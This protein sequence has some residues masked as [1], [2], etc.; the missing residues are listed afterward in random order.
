MRRGAEEDERAEE[1]AAVVDDEKE[2]ESNS[3][4]SVVAD[5]TSGKNVAIVNHGNP[6]AEYYVAKVDLW[7]DVGRRVS[8]ATGSP[9]RTA[10]LSLPSR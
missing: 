7:I 5:I 10:A 1:D 9:T 4:V 3:W 8:R 6:D 2:H